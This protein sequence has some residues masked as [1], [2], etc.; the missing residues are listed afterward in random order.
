MYG[1]S[2]AL[3]ERTTF[4]SSKVTTVDW[5]SYH[6]LGIENAPKV[7][8]VL[9]GANGIAPDGKFTNPQGAAEPAQD[10]TPAAI[11][12]AIYDATG[13]R[14]RRMPMTPDVVLEALKAAGK[15]L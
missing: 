15:A 3:Y 1:T 6:I 14:V 12:N 9:V 11:A 5:E 4:D 7:K 13:V 8:V 2:R 10:A